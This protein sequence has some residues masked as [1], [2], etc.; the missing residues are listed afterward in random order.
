MAGGPTTLTGS[1]DGTPN[2][3]GVHRVEKA[4]LPG[5]M[6][7]E[8]IQLERL[9]K[10]LRTVAALEVCAFALLGFLQSRRPCFLSIQVLVLG[11]VVTCPECPTSADGR[12]HEPMADAGLVK[13]VLGCHCGLG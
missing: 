2:G 5:A 9:Q 7:E 1:Q 8:A 10:E 13:N 12:E 6:S 3:D 4:V 11:R